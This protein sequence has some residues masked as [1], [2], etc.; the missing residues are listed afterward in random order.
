MP[1]TNTQK[2]I[3]KIALGAFMRQ[4]RLM[5]DITREAPDKQFLVLK[6][7]KT[8]VKLELLVI[9]GG[10]LAVNAVRALYQRLNKQARCVMII[11]QVTTD[12][13]ERLREED[14]QFMDTAGNC[15]IDQPPFYIFIKGNKLQGAVKVPVVGRAFKQTGL[16]VLYALLCNPGLENETYR[17]IAAK[18]NVALGM[19]N[20]VLNELI[21]LGYLLE[22]GKGRARHIRLI[23]KEKLLQR[24]ITGYA[25]QLRPKLLIGRYRGADGWW[26]KA[27]LNPEKAQWGG[28]VAAGKLTNYLKPQ[29]ITVYVDK[30]N[31]EAVLI[32]NR[33]KKD[34]GGD[35]ELLHRF[36]QPDT[37]VPQGD[38]VHP[39]L[40]YAD[41][42]AIGNQR[43]IETARILY[44]E[45][46]VQLIREN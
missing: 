26:Q 35:V 25:E 32:Q 3:Q 5:Y 20:W 17:T 44:D 7:P 9:E 41:L 36:W 38:T 11:P 46:I 4:T 12:M 8:P 30:D 28:E 15:F 45:H 22:T 2:H 39:I 27:L 14:T 10:A 29:T 31:P 16:K 40:I 1:T 13:A 23:E 18:T 34:P 43:N 24:W 6:T 37:I 42:M 33:L 19:V 21:E